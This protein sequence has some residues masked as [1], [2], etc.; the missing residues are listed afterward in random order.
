MKLLRYLKLIIQGFQGESTGLGY[1]IK[2]TET[3]RSI[4]HRKADNHM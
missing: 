4:I 2:S 3:V 1:Y